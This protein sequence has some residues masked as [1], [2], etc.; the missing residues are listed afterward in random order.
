LPPLPDSIVSPLI[1]LEFL[2][3]EPSAEAALGNLVPKLLGPDLSFEV[4]SFQGKPDLLRSLPARLRGYRRW[5]P[6][7]WGIVVLIDSDGQDCRAQ[8]KDLE[9]MAGQAG[10]LTRAAAGGH[11]FQVLNRLAIEEL[12]AFFFGDVEALCD[13]YPGVPRSL[14]N[15]S[16]Y[17]DPDAISG[18]WE[19]LERVLQRAG[20]HRGG[21]AKI[22]AAREISA[23]MEPDRNRSR[24]FQAFRQ[25]LLDLVGA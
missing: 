12:E 22:K 13:A 23:C 10:F 16:R 18:T 3:E 9:D 14:G 6:E 20:Y 21:L 1:H 19:A 15:R 5:I 2:V 11:R 8:K 17:R 24:S 25:G 4:Y 7:D